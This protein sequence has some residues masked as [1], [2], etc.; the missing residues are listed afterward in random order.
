[1]NTTVAIVGSHPDTRS[2][3]PFD[4][5]RVDIWVFNEAAGQKVKQDD[6][7][8]KPWAWRVNAVFQMH[9]PVIYRSIHNRSDPDHW[10]WLQKKH[11]FPIYML[12]KDDLVPSSVKYPIDQLKASLSK[13]GQGAD[14]E[15]CN[16]VTNTISYAIALAIIQGYET[17]LVYGVEMGSNTEYTYQRDNVAFWTGYALGRGVFLRFYSGDD[18]FRKPLYGYEG[19]V[20]HTP[21]DFAERIAELE[22]EAAKL[23]KAKTEADEALYQSYKNGNLNECIST[24]GDVAT[25]LGLVDGALHEAMRY[26]YKIVDM[27]A[28]DGSAYIDRNEFEGKAGEIKHKL[29]ENVQN[30]YR[31][32]GRI[33][34]PFVVWQTSKKP[35][36]LEQL[37]KFVNTHIQATYDSGYARGIWDE[38]RA[39][40]HKWD[41][42]VTAAGGDK[43]LA[44]AHDI[45]QPD[46]S[47]EK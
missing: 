6:G 40:S 19:R 12:E 17:I 20:E 16:F 29:E 11:K 39:L 13:F 18:M 31:T 27:W 9:K 5:P 23:R 14:G 47:D 3:A 38:N 24:A 28:Q 8:Y 2:A 44:Y 1:M 21:E 7:E 41:E 15:E 25:N 37:R 30:V 10:E 36:A 33:D 46:G 43:A 34:Y 45:G 35:E 4:D 26:H 22:N 32:A 42:L